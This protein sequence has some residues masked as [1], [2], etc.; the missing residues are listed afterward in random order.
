MS[1]PYQRAAAR[2]KFGVC[3]SAVRKPRRTRLALIALL[4]LLLGAAGTKLAPFALAATRSTDAFLPW[5][6]DPRVRYEPGAEDVAARV[7]VA[8][9]EAIHLVEARLSGPFAQPVTVFVCAGAACLDRFGAPASAAGNVLAGRLFLAPKLAATPERVP[10]VLAHELTHLHVAMRVGT[11]T[12][13]GR[14]PVWF[15]EGLAVDVSGG[16]GAEDVTADEARRALVEKRRFEPI[17]PGALA[18]WFSRRGAR[19][20]GLD[21]HLFYRQAGMFVG[22]LRAADEAKF[23]TFVRAIEQG[24]AIGPALLHAY[25]EPVPVMWRRFLEANGAPP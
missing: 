9:P 19:Y 2:A 17:A 16:A 1:R 5:P 24:D 21:A 13:S 12:W 8:L 4:V 25:G 22:F 14:H 11:V 3:W 10:G 6:A 15:D 18:S 7:A 23:A 20:Y